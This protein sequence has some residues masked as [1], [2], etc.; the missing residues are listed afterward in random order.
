MLRVL[1]AFFPAVIVA[2]VLAA[3]LVTQF[4]LGSLQSMGVPVSMAD[5]LGATFHDL[6]GLASSY[7][8]LILVAF[9]LGFPVAAGLARL[10]PRQRMMLY[11]L[12]GGVAILALHL[13]MKAVLGLSGIAATR[14]LGGLL[15]QGLAGAVGGY[16]F[17]RLSL[18]R[19]VAQQ[20]E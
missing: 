10:L 5:R 9:I 15:S 13:V 4:N 11:V 3:I 19:S 12:A 1:K 6:V 14:S 8:L 2:Y 16:L 18:P 7:L 17:H 20:I